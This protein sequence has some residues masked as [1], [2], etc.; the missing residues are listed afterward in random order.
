M[1]KQQNKYC[2]FLCFVWFIMAPTSKFHVHQGTSKSFFCCTTY[3][4]LRSDWHGRFPYQ[5]FGKF[6][7][8]ELETVHLGKVF[9]R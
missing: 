3:P 7:S 1:E 8:K 9:F 5:F 6:D 2:L 4:K